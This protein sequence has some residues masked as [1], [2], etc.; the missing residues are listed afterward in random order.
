MLTLEEITSLGHIQL[1]LRDGGDA[2]L[3]SNEIAG[4]RVRPLG[5]SLDES[6]RDALVLTSCERFH[7]RPKAWTAFTTDAVKHGVAAIGLA[8]CELPHP[9]LDRSADR[10]AVLTWPASIALRDVAEA[11]EDRLSRANLSLYRRMVNLQNSLIEAVSGARPSESLIRQLGRVL[12][13]SVILYRPDGRVLTSTGEAPSVAI[14]TAINK[15][16]RSVQR[17]EAGR[18]HVVASPTSPSEQPIRWI[19]VATLEHA[20]SEEL[21]VP[22]TK[23][24]EQLLAVIELARAGAVAEDQVHRA[25]MLD[26]L[27]R[28]RQRNPV[29]WERLAPFGFESHAPSWVA[30][31]A[32]HGWLSGQLDAERHAS[33]VTAVIQH[34]RILTADSSRPSLITRA[35]QAVALLVQRAPCSLLEEW[36]ANLA[37]RGYPMCAGIGRGVSS[38]AQIVDSYEDARLALDGALHKSLFGS[39]LVQ[40]FDDFS[41]ADVAVSTG[42]QDQLLRRSRSLV[43]RLEANQGLLE[44][45]VTYLDNDLNV[46]QTAETLHIHPNSVR[47]RLGRVEALVGAPLREVATLVDLYL[48]LRVLARHRD[49]T[50]ARRPTAASHDEYPEDNET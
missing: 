44:A 26:Q 50:A 8:A 11:V 4:V 42:A 17:F 16:T 7:D 37:G 36:L 20:A 49:V 48:A 19:V 22:L 39:V 25:E 47:Y 31:V 46:I 27:L 15:D 41:V 10:L 2:S 13:G 28:N 21:A 30:V 9:F 32:G 5:A 34:L 1:E 33:E 43:A 12:G 3:R 6:D 23:T 38:L 40:R 35:D 45:L 24:A 14:W 29:S 18:W